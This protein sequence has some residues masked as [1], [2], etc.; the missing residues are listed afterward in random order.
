VDAV[1][2]SVV[3]PSTVVHARHLCAKLRARLPKL[4]VVIGLWGATENLTEAADRLRKSG[5]DE[6]A[7]SLAEAV[8][9]LS[10]IR[11]E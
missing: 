3:A 1:C 2:I 10:K 9:H 6:I 8:K 11:A 5:A 4:K 7:G